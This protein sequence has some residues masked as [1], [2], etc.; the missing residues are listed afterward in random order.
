MKHWK[1]RISNDSARP[2]SYIV[3]SLVAQFLVA[4][5]SS[6]AQ[7]IV[8]ILR[9]IYAAYSPYLKTG[10]VPII[11]DPGFPV[12][13]VAK[14]WTIHEFS[15]FINEVDSALATASAALEERDISKSIAMWK[16][17]FGEEFREN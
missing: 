14:R 16:I 3:E 9:S 10:K 2:N 13:N 12:V 15:S 4:I 6:Y 11:S 7:G 17:L 1:D 5:P 8:N